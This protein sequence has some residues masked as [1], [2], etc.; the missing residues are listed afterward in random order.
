MTIMSGYVTKIRT[1]SGDLQIDYNALANK[2]E[3]P[4]KLQDFGITATSTELN[5]VI[6]TKG[7]IQEQ[8]DNVIASLPDEPT[9][10]DLGI[11]VTSEEINNV[12]GSSGAVQEQMQDQI[13]KKLDKS[14]GAM[15]GALTTHGV[16][17]TEGVDYGTEYPS[18]ATDGQV[19]FVP[20]VV[21]ADYIV[22]QGIT[23]DWTWR[24]WNSGIAECWGIH[25]VNSGE[26][27]EATTNIRYSKNAPLISYPN[28]LFIDDN[29]IANVTVNAAGGAVIAPFTSTSARTYITITLCRIAGGSDARDVY[30]NIHTI[31]I[32]E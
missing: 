1:T 12:V 9:L 17:L 23:D 11:S 4:D 30:L 27:F 25:K 18:S 7:P 20:D 26:W 19:F 29:P 28:G 2:P 22:E 15:T 6:G 16:I 5:N 10:E 32:C 3:I 31:G 8:I 21:V 13:N 14:G 24:K